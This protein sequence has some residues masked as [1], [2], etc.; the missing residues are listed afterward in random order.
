M[1]VYNAKIVYKFYKD[2]EVPTPV[3]DHKSIHKED[4]SPAYCNN[5]LVWH[6]E[7]V[8]LQ[9]DVWNAFGKCT[10]R[11][12]HAWYETLVNGAELFMKPEHIKAQI[13]IFNEIERQN[14]LIYKF[15]KPADCI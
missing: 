15:E 11:F 2:E 12:Y 7:E 1:K 6:E 10:N 3:L 13:A 8:E 9:A 4:G 14:P 5:Q